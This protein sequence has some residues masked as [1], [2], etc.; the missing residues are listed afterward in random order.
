MPIVRNFIRHSSAQGLHEYFT[1]KNIA[2]S[3]VDWSQDQA[4]VASNVIQLLDHLPAEDQARL[5]ID[6]ERINQMADEIGQAA[7]LSAVTNTSQ[8]SQMESALERSRWVY[9]HEP[10][11]FRHAEDIRYADQYRHGRNWSGYQLPPSL[12]LHTDQVSLNTFKEK[13]KSLFGLGDKV[14]VELFDRSLLDDDGNDVDVVQV[15][16]YQEGLPDAYLEFEGDEDIVSRIRRPVSEHAITYSPDSG[17]MEIVAAKRER[18]EEIA[19]SFTEDLLKQTVE[20]DKV[21]LRQYCLDPLL[22]GHGLDWDLD[23]HIDSVQLVML[24]LKDLS[25]DGR[26]QIEVPAKNEVNF[27]DYCR[28]HFSDF[29]PLTSK[30]FAPIQAVISIRFQPEQG[31]NRKKVLPVKISLPNGCDLRSRTERERLIGEKY[32]K[33]W[34][35]VREI[36]P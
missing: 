16:I 30:S 29:N 15:M 31:S 34:G 19:K 26:I 21:P 36:N 6:A 3:G 2:V 9:L 14:K 10:D 13:M 17:T 25:G 33:Q 22:N 5:R 1:N 32:L 27:H 8:L 11:R 24:K 23:D 18:R 7:L 20:A 28:E 35:L 12:P 4:T